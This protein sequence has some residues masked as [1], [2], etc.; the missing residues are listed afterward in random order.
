MA[1]TGSIMNIRIEINSYGFSV[2]V[3][4][5]LADFNPASLITTE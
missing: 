2:I 3:K 1:V 5:A 4:V